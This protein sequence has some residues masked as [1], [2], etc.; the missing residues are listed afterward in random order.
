M[1]LSFVNGRE[2]CCVKFKLPRTNAIHEQIRL[3]W[4]AKKKWVQQQQNT[5]HAY[6]EIANC[7]TWGVVASSCRFSLVKPNEKFLQRAKNIN[8][9]P[10]LLTLQ[11]Q[12]FLFWLRLWEPT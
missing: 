9:F 7:T 2:F 11:N 10:P 4:R 8:F 6:A 3:I 1:V 12:R 5:L